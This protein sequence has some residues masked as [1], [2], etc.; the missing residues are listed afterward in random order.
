MGILVLNDKVVS[1]TKIIDMLS[2][3]M[4]RKA[5]KLVRSLQ[6]MMNPAIR[7]VDKMNRTSLIFYSSSR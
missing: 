2:R 7:S 3:K 4:G 5:S 1:G 6:T